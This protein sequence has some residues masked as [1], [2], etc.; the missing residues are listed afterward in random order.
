MTAKKAV[1]IFGFAG[2]RSYV[3][4]ADSIVALREVTVSDV[5]LRK[6]SASQSVAILNDSVIAKNAASLTALLSYNSLIYFKENGLGMVSSPA[7]RGTTAQQTAVI[8]NGLNI[9][10]QLNGQTD[11]NTV[12][13]ANYDH[14]SVRAGG[15]SA[16]TVAVPLAAACIWAMICDSATDSIMSLI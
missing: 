12:T 2:V 10:S 3:R 7:F 15:G 6:F 1:F 5:S 16:F 4:A 13:T 8:W 14:I 11:F 9:N